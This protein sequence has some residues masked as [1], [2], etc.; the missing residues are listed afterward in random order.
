MF[1]LQSCWL[2]D[3]SL[4]PVSRPRATPAIV[5]YGGYAPLPMLFQQAENVRAPVMY[6]TV[7]QEIVACPDHG[8][9]I[10]DAD[11]RVVEPLL[12]AGRPPGHLRG[13]L[14]QL[15]VRYLMVP[16]LG[17]GPLRDK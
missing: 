13:K 8:D 11:K 10:V 6:F 9:I 4:R 5:G 12:Q 2:R 7:D 17:R 3:L 14:A 15:R 16:G 1:T